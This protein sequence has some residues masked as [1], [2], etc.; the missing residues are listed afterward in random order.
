MDRH[1]TFDIGKKVV[2]RIHVDH[3]KMDVFIND[4]HVRTIPVTAGMAGYATRSGT[5]IIMEKY[6]GEF[7]HGAPRSVADQ[8][9]ANVSHGCVGMSL[10]DAHWLY[11][12][13]SRGDVVHVTGTKRQIEPGNGYTDWNVS[14]QDYKQGSALS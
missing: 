8:G 7:I 14:Y 6:S 4:R 11:E 10:S 1:V 9:E 12:R 13:S 3:Q 5:K 2:S